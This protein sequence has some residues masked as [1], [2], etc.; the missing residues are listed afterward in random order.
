VGFGGR[1][2]IFERD[3]RMHRFVTFITWSELNSQCYTGTNYTERKI[4]HVLISHSP[5]LHRV[6]VR[7]AS[8]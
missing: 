5:I 7:E 4:I 3:G 8:D 6:I 1:N 2:R